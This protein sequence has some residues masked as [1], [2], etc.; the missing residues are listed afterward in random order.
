M[1]TE[2][3]YLIFFTSLTVLA[4]KIASGE[5]MILEG[6]GNYASYKVEEDGNKWY[7]LLR[8]QWC[9]PSVWSSVGFAFAFIFNVLPFEWHWDYIAL[10]ILCVFGSS[11]TC[12]MIW[13][14]YITMNAKR[15]KDEQETEYLKVATKHY[16]NVE[17]LSHWDVSE[18]KERF[19]KRTNGATINNY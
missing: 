2:L 3:L 15:D 1:I 4:W 7:E 5:D 6:V 13:T 9:M 19:N 11:L 18:R 12:G 10:Y 14:M 8:C 16:T 17:K